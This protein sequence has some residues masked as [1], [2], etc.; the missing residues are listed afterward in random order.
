[1]IDLCTGQKQRGATGKTGVYLKLGDKLLR[2]QWGVRAATDVH[3]P[4]EDQKGGL[5]PDDLAAK[6]LQDLVE[7]LVL[8]CVEGADVQHAC[9]Y[10]G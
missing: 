2:V 10:L 4:V 1:M 3:Q 8:E 9:A 6:Q 5:V 7:P